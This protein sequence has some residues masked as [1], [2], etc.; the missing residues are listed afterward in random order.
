MLAETT[1]YYEIAAQLPPDD[2]WLRTYSG[3]GSGGGGGTRER[4]IDAV[5]GA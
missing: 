4:K 1:N 5:R 2:E 3:S